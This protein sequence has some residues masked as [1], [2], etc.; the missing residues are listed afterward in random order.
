M[1]GLG[2]MG[3]D[4]DSPT[5]HSSLARL[6][7]VASR[8]WTLSLH[9]QRSSV[10]TVQICSFCLVDDTSYLKGQRSTGIPP[11]SCRCHIGHLDSPL[12][13]STEHLTVTCNSLQRSKGNFFQLSYI[14]SF[15]N[16]VLEGYFIL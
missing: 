5:G 8:H 7:N 1:A 12:K 6:V 13:H 16:S 10:L 3:W 2:R 14:I 9:I 11:K 4:E 15:L